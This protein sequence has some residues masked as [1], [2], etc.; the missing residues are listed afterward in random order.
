MFEKKIQADHRNQ[1]KLQR[2]DMLLADLNL[3]SVVDSDVL[4]LDRRLI[5]P[6]ETELKQP[7]S[8]TI[9]NDS[10]E[11]QQKAFTEILDMDMK[12]LKYSR[13]TLLSC[14]YRMF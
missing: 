12:Y 1:V 8:Q 6:L 10:L 2:A 3:P 11:I 4:W 14:W 7:F 5:E 9:K 13:G